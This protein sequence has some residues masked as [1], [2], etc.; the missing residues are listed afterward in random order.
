LAVLAW[1]PTIPSCAP[2]ACELQVQQLGRSADKMRAQLAQQQD[3]L[4]ELARQVTAVHEAQAM[5]RRKTAGRDVGAQ[6]PAH[7]EVVA[8][9]PEPEAGQGAP[10]PGAASAGVD[11]EAPIVITMAA[12]GELR[13]LDGP[14]SAQPPGAQGQA[15]F[16]EALAAV[17]RGRCA[18]AL[19][20]LTTFLQRHPQHPQA[21]TALYWQGDC[22]LELGQLEAA[23]HAFGRLRH[24]HPES[25]K[26]PDALLRVGFAY[27]RLAQPTEARAAFARLL[28]NYPDSAVADVAKGRLAR[29][30]EPTG[31][32]TP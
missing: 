15:L 12:D 16:A 21:G 19:G 4:Q 1:V 13:A 30:G 6:I 9:A 5:A 3:R 31:K 7:L 20:R 22:H 8:L 29:A 17:R 24:E 23:I 2:N 18:D 14:S 10:A 28:S 11:E 25:P 32:G 27:E 26:A